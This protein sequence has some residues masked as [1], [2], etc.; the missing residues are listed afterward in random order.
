MRKEIL[1]LILAF[2]GIAAALL[3]SYVNITGTVTL[4]ELCGNDVVRS[5]FG[6]ECELPNTNNN[7]FCPQA[8]SQCSGALTAT[9]DASGSCDSGCSCDEDPFGQFACL[10]DSCGAQCD[11]DDDCPDSQCSEEFF[12]ICSGPKLTE[13]DN[14][15]ILDSTVVQNSVS[16]TCDTASTC[17]CSNNPVSCDA[18]ATNTYCVQGVCSAECDQDVDCPPNLDEQ[19]DVCFFSGSCDTQTSCSCSYQSESCPEPGI[20]QNNECFFR[21]QGCDNTGCTTSVCTLQEGQICDSGLGCTTTT[22]TT[23]TSTT[24]TTTPQSCNDYCISLGPSFSGGSCRTTECILTEV[25][26]GQDGCIENEI[27]CCTLS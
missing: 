19:S 14:D 3:P 9:R 10:K 23:S 26:V 8:T 20:V 21:T 1:V 16:N 5:Q 7:Q 12:D 11:S 22:T 25:D 2:A 18:P 13:Y 6:E 17:G 4:N 24:T 27:C 15:M